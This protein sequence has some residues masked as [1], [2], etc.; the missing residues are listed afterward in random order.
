MCKCRYH[1]ENIECCASDP[2]MLPSFSYKIGSLFTI[3]VSIVIIH[4]FEVYK[5]HFIYS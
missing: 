5:L 4:Y 2:V 3:S 1:V